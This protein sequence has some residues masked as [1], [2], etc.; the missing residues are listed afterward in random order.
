MKLTQ[1]DEK[2]EEFFDYLNTG[3]LGATVCVFSILGG[4]VV[5]GTLVS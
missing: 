3:T 5:L 4:L 2:F 1:I